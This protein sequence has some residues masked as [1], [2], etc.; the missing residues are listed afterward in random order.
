VSNIEQVVEEQGVYFFFE[1]VF[2]DVNYFSV[3][4]NANAFDKR[5]FQSGLNLVVFLKA[6]CLEKITADMPIFKI[7]K[8][9]EFGKKSLNVAVGFSFGIERAFKSGF[10]GD[11]GAFDE[12][13][14]FEF[15]FQN[16]FPPFYFCFSAKRAHLFFFTHLYLSFF[17]FQNAFFLQQRPCHD[18][19]LL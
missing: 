9:S 4:V 8:V 17:F 18:F 7:T 11:Q 6:K 1:H 13:S 5:I 14:V 12:D 15:A 10:W 19:L 3:F 2:F 16:I